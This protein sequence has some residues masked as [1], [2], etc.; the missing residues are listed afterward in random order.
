METESYYGLNVCA[1]HRNSSV[2]ILT[3]SVTVLG[4][5]IQQWGLWEVLRWWN[6]KVGMASRPRH[7]ALSVTESTLLREL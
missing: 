3:P 2:E 5:S 1:P 6:S 4:D 7:K